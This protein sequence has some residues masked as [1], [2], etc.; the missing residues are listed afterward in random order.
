MYMHRII[1]IIIF[2]ATFLFSQSSRVF[3]LETNRGAKINVMEDF[4]DT[5]KGEKFS[6]IIIAPGSR[7]PMNRPIIKLMAEESVKN[8]VAVFRF[9]WHYYSN[10]GRPS[11]GSTFEREELQTVLDYVRNHP[12]IDPDKIILAGKSFGSIIAYS[13]FKKNKDIFG[14]FLLTPICNKENDIQARYPGL[15]DVK[16]NTV[17]LL[18]N[19]DPLCALGFLYDGLGNSGNNIATVVISGDH[20]L[21]IDPEKIGKPQMTSAENI[22][23]AVNSITYWLTILLQ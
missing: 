8:G 18:G 20:G 19:E 23:F 21:N 12:R 14:L 3:E 11:P 2:L 4:P 16:R 7:Y 22:Q 17:I 10:R 9:N 1:C 5:Q 13:I 15:P 6:A